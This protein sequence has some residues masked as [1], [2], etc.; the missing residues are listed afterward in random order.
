MTSQQVGNPKYRASALVM[1][2]VLREASAKHPGVRLL[3]LRGQ[4]CND[5]GCP[6]VLAGTRVYDPTAHPTKP[7]RARL[8]NWVLNTM[9]AKAGA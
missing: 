8:A 5:D 7:A 9:F 6:K 4:L 3:D 2:R 1:N